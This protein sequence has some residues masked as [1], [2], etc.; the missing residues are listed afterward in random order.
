MLRQC[1]IHIYQLHSRIELTLV[2]GDIGVT[3]NNQA[4]SLHSSQNNTVVPIGFSQ[5]MSA[6]TQQHNK[7][8][9]SYVG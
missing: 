3:E 1:A 8:S 9:K 4:Y 6:N 2:D 7:R 5:R